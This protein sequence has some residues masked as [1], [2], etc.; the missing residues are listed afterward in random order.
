[1]SARPAPPSYLKDLARL[2]RDARRG[3]YAPYSRFKVGAAL[4]T[5]EG[6]VVTG[7]NMENAS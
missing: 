1:M 2:A 6:E 4:R 7:C 3:A 5:R